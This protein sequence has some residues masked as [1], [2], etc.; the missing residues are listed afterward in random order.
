MSGDIL[1]CHSWMGVTGIAVQR[2]GA[3]GCSTMPPARDNAAQSVA[4]V[5]AHV[6]VLGELGAQWDAQGSRIHSRESRFNLAT[7]KCLGGCLALP[8]S[9]R[10][11][12]VH[13]ICHLAWAEGALVAGQL[14]FW[15]CL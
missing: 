13:S 12:M 10:G 8:L 6:I 2:P 11:V 3:A 15:V 9:G 14:Y 7:T 5:L 1:E 4:R